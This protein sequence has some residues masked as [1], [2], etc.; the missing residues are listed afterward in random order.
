MICNIV[1]E[2]IQRR[3]TDG[4]F[5]V[6]SGGSREK[7]TWVDNEGPILVRTRNGEVEVVVEVSGYK[8]VVVILARVLSVRINRPDYFY[9]FGKLFEKHKNLGHLFPSRRFVLQHHDGIS[10]NYFCQPRSLDC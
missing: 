5:K 6:R 9:F 4:R 1:Q 8:K 10:R 7:R 3:R 2:K